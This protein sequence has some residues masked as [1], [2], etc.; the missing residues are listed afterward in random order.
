MPLVHMDDG[1]R[2]WMT[3]PHWLGEFGLPFPPQPGRVLFQNYPMVLQ[4]ALAGRGVALGWR[5]LIDDLVNGR[6]ARGRRA[7]GALRPRLLRH[8]APGRAVSPRCMP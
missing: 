2:P 7:R 1:D 4:Q 5:P 8:L 3:W 6:R